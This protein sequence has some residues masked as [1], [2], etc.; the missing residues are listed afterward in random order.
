MNT[1]FSQETLTYGCYNWRRGTLRIVANPNQCNPSYE[2]YIPWH[3][4]IPP[5]GFTLY[6]YVNGA[7]GVDSPGRGLTQTDSFQTITYA[8]QQL[9]Y[10]RPTQEIETFIYV[11]PTIYDENLIITGDNIQILKDESYSGDVIIDRGGQDVITIDGAH[12]VV[13][14]K[15]IVQN[16]NRGIIGKSGSSFE[17]RGIEVRNCEDDGIQVV[18]NS[19]ALIKNC[20]VSRS[21]R[22]GV[23][24]YNTSSATITGTLICTLNDIDGLIISESSSAYINDANITTDNNSLH[25]IHVAGS[26]ALFSYNSTIFANNNA[27]DGINTMEVS[28]LN[29]FD[30][31]VTTSGN[32][33]NGI[34]IHL[35]SNGKFTGGVESR[36]NSVDGLSI[37]DNSMLLSKTLTVNS[38]ARNGISI[39][40]GSG[41][42]CCNSVISINNGDDLF[43]TFSSRA[44]LFNNTIGEITSDETSL[45]RN[46]NLCYP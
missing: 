12:K 25:G 44:N 30:S 7:T 20:T 18:D 43:L 28:S 46:I 23:G 33:R 34:S 31:N 15:V 3:K 14:S 4:A 40:N 45:I 1:A 42:N 26:S 37:R 29:L 6:I 16:G 39:D 27:R 32:G 36:G 19:T 35:N 11:S 38:N 13:I 22:Y 21:G 41:I 2:S 8:L 9:I 5:G 10:L 24:I 17:V